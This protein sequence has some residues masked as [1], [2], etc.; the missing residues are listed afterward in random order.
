MN[1]I[2]GALS[3]AIWNT[4]LTN[5]A[6]SPMNFCTNSEPTISIKVLLVLFAT[7]F[8][9]KVLPVP[10]GPCRSMPLGGVIPTFL[11]ISGFLRGNSTTSFKSLS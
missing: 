9:S 11:K 4:S 3:L 10:G 5:L 6:P 8:A 1:I 2:L 7:A